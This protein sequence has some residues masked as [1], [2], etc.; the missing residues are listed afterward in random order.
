MLHF[1]LYDKNAMPN[2]IRQCLGGNAPKGS[3]PAQLLDP[4]YYYQD[5][6]S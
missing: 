5:S 3:K 6:A 1:E 4:S 2:E